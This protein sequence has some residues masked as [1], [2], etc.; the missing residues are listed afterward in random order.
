MMAAWQDLCMNLGLPVNS[1]QAAVPKIH[2]HLEF[3]S[4]PTS[5]ALKLGH[6]TKKKMNLKNESEFVMVDRQFELM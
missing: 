1:K 2:W 6:P 5:K 3:K 4:S